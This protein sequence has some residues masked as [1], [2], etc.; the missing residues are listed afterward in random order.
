M[1]K[2]KKVNIHSFEM[3]LLETPFDRTYKSGFP[4]W[5]PELQRCY[6]QSRENRCQAPIDVQAV[7]S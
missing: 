1:T 4:F 7:P 5:H 6:G 3:N 2:A